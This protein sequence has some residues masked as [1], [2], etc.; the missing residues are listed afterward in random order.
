MGEGNG[1]GEEA[2]V[3]DA[4]KEAQG[5]KVCEDWRGCY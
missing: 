5:N 3:D 1:T 2:V 4:I